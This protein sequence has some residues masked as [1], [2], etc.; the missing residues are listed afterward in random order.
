MDKIIAIAI[1]E[2]QSDNIK[3]LNNCLNDINSLIGILTENYQYDDLDIV[4]FNKPEQTTLSFLYNRLNEEF[5][6]SLEDNTIL[7]IYAGHGDYNSYLGTSYWYCSDSE[8]HDPTTWFNVR[9]LLDF[10]SSSSAKHISLISDS[11]FSGAIFEHTRGG[12]ISALTKNKSRQALT[13]GGIESVSDGKQKE[14][15]SPFNLVLQKVLKENL[16]SELTF[17]QLCEDAIKIF[18]PYIKQTPQYGSLFNT[19]D[20]G[21]TYVFKRKDV[22]SDLI[23]QDLK[24]ALDINENIKIETDFKIPFLKRNIKFN[25]DFINAFIQQLGYSI[26]SDI[27]LYLSDKN[28]EKYFIERS[29]QIGFSLEVGYTINRLDDNFLSIIIHRS[30]YFGT[31]YPNHYIYSVNFAFNPDRKINLFDLID[32]P[33]S[34]SFM[35]DLINEHADPECR[36]FLKQYVSYEYIKDLNFSFDNEKL[37]LYFNNLLPHAFQACGYIELP[38]ERIKLNDNLIKNLTT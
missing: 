34:E 22:L 21:G 33:H 14:N 13:S 3:N 31:A 23:V 12:G 1:D 24:L 25:A 19:G 26:V 35:K 29:N 38:I 5:R 27:R 20:K 16:S 37:Y 28:E 8:S 6:N 7:V 17:N 15:N 2:Y 10:F 11:C 36:E 4:L 18:S 30:E 32:I 9:D